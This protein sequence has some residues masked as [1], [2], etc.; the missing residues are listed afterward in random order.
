MLTLKQVAEVR[1]HLE[2]AQNPIF[3]FDNDPDGLCSFLLLRRYIERGRGVSIK[4][5]P[6]LTP[7]YF[8]KV[9]ELGADYIFILDKPVV[10]EQFFELVERENIPVVWIDHHIVDKKEIPKFVNYYNPTLNRKKTDEPV[11]ALCYQISK[12]KGD[13]WIAL[14]G[15]ISDQF[16]PGFYGDFEKEYPELAIKTK[17]VADIFYKS[18]I[19]KIAK[20]FSAGLKDRT[21]NVVNMIRLL[22]KVKSPYE[23]LE[24]NAKTRSLL[25]RFREIDDKYQILLK[26]AIFLGQKSGNVLF[27]RYGGD[28]SISGEL[29]NELSYNFPDKVI[30]VAY[31]KG[32]KIN[33]SLRGKKVR[34]AFLE[35][36]ADLE[37][38]TGG[39]HENAVGGQ[40]KIEDFEKFKVNLEKILTR[41]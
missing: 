11:T 37:D 28:L 10:S 1:A 12:R 14:I 41:E 36:I 35:S 13:M 38:A 39:G 19:G 3:F 8:S 34:K 31:V 9:K 30:V 20:I 29:S 40:M 15:S 23:V 32:I 7:E 33:V 21:T 17:K 24:E 16:L 27:F 6:S 22:T 26:K 2:K 25:N 4:S 18:G 5:F